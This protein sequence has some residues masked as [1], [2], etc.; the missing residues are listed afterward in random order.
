MALIDWT[1]DAIQIEK[2]L[3]SLFAQYI[4]FLRLSSLKIWYRAHKTSW[5]YLYVIQ[6]SKNRN[7]MTIDRNN[8]CNAMFVAIRNGRLDHILDTFTSI[9]NILNYFRVTLI[10]FVPISH[11][12]HI[13]VK[14]YNCFHQK[15][16]AWIEQKTSDW[17]NVKCVAQLGLFHALQ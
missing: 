5:Q 10:L 1:N 15:E 11:S 4:S 14:F 17:S 2:E 8:I 9:S 7:F 13:F 16:S 3:T 12:I 6:F